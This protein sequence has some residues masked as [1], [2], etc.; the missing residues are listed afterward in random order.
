MSARRQ[1]QDTAADACS[2]E[3]AQTPLRP[4]KTVIVGARGRM[5]SMLLGRARNAG[6][7]VAGV[8]TPLTAQT[9]APACADAE[10]DRKSVV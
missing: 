8:D 6:L 2:G 9:L 1:R 5:G 3:A 10:L 7:A 4:V